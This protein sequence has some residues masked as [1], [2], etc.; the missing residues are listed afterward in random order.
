MMIRFQRANLPEGK[1]TQIP[2]RQPRIDP[3]QPQQEV[4]LADS[5]REGTGS[6]SL[7]CIM[8]SRGTNRDD[9]LPSR[10]AVPPIG[11][12]R[13]PHT[14]MQLLDKGL[15]NVKKTGLFITAVVEWNGFD[16]LNKTWNEFKAHFTEAYEA[17][18]DSG[19]TAA[20]AGYH[21]A[22]NT[23]ALANDDDDNSLGS[24]A[25]SLAQMQMASNANAKVIH[26][27]ISGISTG[28]TEL[29][30]A[31]LATQQQVAALAR[32]I[33]TQGNMPAWSP[34][35]AAPPAG[36]P[37]YAVQPPPP[38]PY[39]TAYANAA[40]QGIPPPAPPAYVAVPPNFG[41]GRGR[42]GRGRG[43]RGR[44]RGGRGA[45]FQPHPPAYYHQAAG[46]PA[47]QIPGGIPPLP[48]EA[49]DVEDA[50]RHPRTRTKNTIIGTRASV[51]DLT[52]PDGTTA[53]L[54]QDRAWTAT[55]KNTRVKKV[56]N[57]LM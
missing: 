45:G 37:A 50:A 53:K 21:G 8:E 29:R 54:A 22:A 46:Q 12:R 20:T 34:P 9:V 2:N 56:S 4:R 51:A 36:Y 11:T 23:N 10:G 24:I 14:S 18:L 48:E 39:M 3:C 52:C 17:R 57:T 40:A 38:P 35:P 28:T 43:R 7:E 47:A 16:E 13:H 33:N 26:D 55:R 19:P 30:Q 5:C 42:G 44:G 1:K 27:S 31:L 6:H 32:A 49:E 25:G 41:G 15:D